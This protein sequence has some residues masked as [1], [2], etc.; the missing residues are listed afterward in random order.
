GLAERA[1]AEVARA[2]QQYAAERRALLFTPTVRV[3]HA[4][5]DALR[6]RGVRADAVDGAT[7]ITDRRAIL[8]R[9]RHGDTRVIANCAVLTEGYD[10]PSADCI[11]VA[12][13]TRSRPLYIQM[14]G[15]GT[16]RY[17]GKPDCV[18]LDMAGATNRHDLVTTA[19]L[20]GVPATGAIEHSVLDALDDAQ[21]RRQAD[22]E[23]AERGQLV[24]R[25]IDLFRARPLNWIPVNVRR[26]ALAV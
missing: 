13:P 22:E 23:R 14:I 3:A 24:G 5:V 8:A 19:T 2:F 16:R 20:F 1:P 11:I 18:V 25:A 7:P 12:R 6:G 21:A 10:E 4:M 17:P 9:F 26:F 15:R